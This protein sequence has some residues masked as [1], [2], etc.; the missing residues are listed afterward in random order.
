MRYKLWGNV[1][2]VH[3]RNAA[4]KTAALRVWERAGEVGRF[5]MLAI[6]SSR[7]VRLDW[8]SQIFALAC[9]D[10]LVFK[11]A[12]APCHCWCNL[13]AWLSAYGACCWSRSQGKMH[14]LYQAVH[15]FL[16]A[17]AVSSDACMTRH[18][19]FVASRNAHSGTNAAGSGE[20]LALPARQQTLSSQPHMALL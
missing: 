5:G 20:A 1:T 6:A 18:P 7:P 4:Y 19:I 15:E 10:A 2:A 14:C 9:L 12:C 11:S 17:L 3:R 13:D 8:L 16:L